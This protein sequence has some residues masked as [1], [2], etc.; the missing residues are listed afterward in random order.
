MLVV[1]PVVLLVHQ[2]AQGM[3][4]EQPLGVVV[5]RT[6]V[7]LVAWLGLLVGLSYLAMG[8]DME[9]VKHC[10]QFSFMVRIVFF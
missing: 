6:V 5:T 7:A 4:H 2:A 10:Y 8:G 9:W 3:E 1:V